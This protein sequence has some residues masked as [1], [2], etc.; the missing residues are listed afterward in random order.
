VTVQEWFALAALL[1]TPLV[2]IAKLLINLSD[3]QIEIKRALVGDA[4]G[5]PG[6]V[7]EFAAMKESQARMEVRVDEIEHR[8]EAMEETR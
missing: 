5:H 2:F 1:A 8:L 4:Y 6:L 7:K 3:G